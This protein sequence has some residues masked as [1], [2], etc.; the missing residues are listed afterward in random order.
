MSNYDRLYKNLKRFCVRGV[1]S[2]YYLSFFYYFDIMFKLVVNVDSHLLIIFLFLLDN[3]IDID[4]L[5]LMKESDLEKLIQPIGQ[6]VKFRSKWRAWLDSIE[7]PTNV[8]NVTV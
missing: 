6:M 5:K 4:T 8:D 2:Q 7:L 1:I 3:M